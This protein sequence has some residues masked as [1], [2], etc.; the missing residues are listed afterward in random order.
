[1]NIERTAQLLILLNTVAVFVLGYFQWVRPRAK[2]RSEVHLD[3]ATEAEKVAAAWRTTVEGM[4][5]RINALQAGFSDLETAQ[6]LDRASIKTLTTEVA[7]LRRG[8][9][10]LVDQIERAGLSPVWRPSAETRLG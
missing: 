10:L 1:M 8:A 4:Q 7:E 9:N 2:P 3:E 6:R 5:A